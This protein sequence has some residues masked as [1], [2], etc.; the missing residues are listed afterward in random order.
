MWGVGSGEFKV[1]EDRDGERK[2][3][4][5]GAEY[6]AAVSRLADSVCSCSECTMRGRQEAAVKEQKETEQRREE[7]EQVNVKMCAALSACVLFFWGGGVLTRAYVQECK[8]EE[9]PLPF[10]K[11][12]GT[13]SLRGKFHPQLL[14]RCCKSSG[15]DVQRSYFVNKR[16]FIRLFLV[17]S[18]WVLLHFPE[19]LLTSQLR[20]CLNL[21]ILSCW[22][23]YL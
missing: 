12:S 18:V 17:Y 6:S 11:K 15:W 22:Y 1:G 7:R 4:Q 21:L 10:G 13:P 3:E 16:V 9:F 20:I 14:L 23:R 8:C 2:G 19:G 5:E